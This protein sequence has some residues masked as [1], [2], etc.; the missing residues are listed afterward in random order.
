[1]KAPTLFGMRFGVLVGFYRWRLREHPVQELLAAAGIAVGVALVF[2]VLVAN[3]SITASARELVH[4]I[5]GSAQL[6]LAA[7]SPDGMPAALADRAAAIPGVIEA[8]PIL[9]Q[10]A[11]L[12]GPDGRQSVEIMGVTPALATLGGDR[13]QGFGAGG[14]RL[15]QGLTLPQPLGKAIGARPGQPVTVLIRGRA[16]RALVGTLLD[17]N[18]I[19]SLAG[20][21]I[22]IAP[23]DVVQSLAGMP[24]R[25]SQ[26]LVHTR[27]SAVTS[28]Q[29]ALREIAGERLDVGPADDELRLLDT[30]AAPNDLSTGLFA[31]ISAIVG[32]LLAVNAMLLTTPERRRWVAELRT[33]GYSARQILLT[34]TFDA[35]IL[36]VVAS[37]L[38][39]LLGNLLSRTLFSDVPA[40]LSFAFPVGSAR[41]VTAT[42]VGLALLAGVGATLLT[43]LLPALDLRSPRPDAIL[44]QAGEAGEAISPRTTRALALAGVAIVAIAALASV[45]IPSLTVVFGG[46]LAA[47]TIC[48]LPAAFAVT[49][50]LLA[51]ATSGLRNRMLPLAV[52]ELRATATRSIALAAV[53]GLAVYGCVAIQ[54]ARS[55][56][57]RGL[58]AN[59]GDYLKTADLW[60]T[61]G[62]DDLTTN[63]FKAPLGAQAALARLPEVRSVRTYQGGL[64]DDGDRRL[65]IIARDTSDRAMIPASQLVDGDLATATRRLRGRGWIA[66]SQAVADARHVGLGERFTLPTPTGPVA[67]RVAAITTNLGWPPGAA[68]VS[69]ADYRRAWA[70]NDPSALQVDLADGVTPTAGKRA[71]QTALGD[72]PGLRVQTVAE[73]TAQYA[74]LSRQG[75]RS[76][77]QIALLLLIAAGLAVALALSAA[78]WQRQPRLA[79]LKVEG[80]SHLQLWR[81]VMLE[82]TIVLLLGGI[83]GALL[84]LYGHLLASRWLE[85]T[86][87]FPAPFSI[88]PEQVVLTIATLAAIALVTLAVPG[89]VATSVPPRAS[90]QD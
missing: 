28:T 31:A 45:V 59:F 53:A 7:R 56:L 90:F 41:I 76:L 46:L 23:L 38:G 51:G 75:L 72:T 74:S 20:N 62:G 65:W 22:A 30:T 85:L 43:S 84:G 14:M 12:V 48:L 4:S 32:F 79:A 52:I 10:Q 18:A 44:T 25:I 19:G 3:T 6:E 70:T 73:R 66:I 87:G 57:V 55:D 16:H 13:T 80:F 58:D 9:R 42:A 54:G 50:T 82:S 2:G 68:I 83:I 40:Y 5:T 36:G 37:A 33:Q 35:L 61:T 11:T 8:A 86:T 27:P 71:I 60:I 63:S 78:L 39:V 24:N 89:Y 1:M 15:A 88:G 17:N 26:V 49:T 29:T 64:L 77:S 67:F 21:P 47:A 81:C 34:L 69:G